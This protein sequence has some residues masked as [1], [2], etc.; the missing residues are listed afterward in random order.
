[1]KEHVGRGA[2]S[3]IERRQHRED[4]GEQIDGRRA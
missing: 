4:S 2:T 1:M 3:G